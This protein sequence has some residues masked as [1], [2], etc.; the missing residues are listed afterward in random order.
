M[1]GAVI[2]IGA[3]AVS[4]AHT[5]KAAEPLFTCLLSYF[6]LGTVFKWQASVP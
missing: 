5:V 4:F 2:S 3:G 6:V 1:A